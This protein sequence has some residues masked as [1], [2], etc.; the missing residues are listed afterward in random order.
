MLT[1]SLRCNASIDGP[2]EEI[3]V[4]ILRTGYHFEWC[5]CGG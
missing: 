4:G 1:I 3:A 5:E 2:A